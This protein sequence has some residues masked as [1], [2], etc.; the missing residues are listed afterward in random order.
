[1]KSAD[2]GFLPAISKGHAAGRDRPCDK[3]LGDPI[4]KNDEFKYRTKHALKIKNQTDED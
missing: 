3:F 4:F 1:M 2:K